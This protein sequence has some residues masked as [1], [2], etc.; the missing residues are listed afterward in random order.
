MA[1]SSKMKA[2]LLAA[3]LVEKMGVEDPRQP[4]PRLD[5]QSEEMV[6]AVAATQSRVKRLLRQ[7]DRKKQ[8]AGLT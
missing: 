1:T 6:I 5:Q 3:L 4:L 8:V 7:L 2:Q